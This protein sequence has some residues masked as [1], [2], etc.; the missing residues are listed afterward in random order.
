MMT[1]RVGQNNESGSKTIRE[2]N[3]HVDIAFHIKKTKPKVE[4]SGMIKVKMVM[5]T[6]Y[7][8]SKITLKSVHIFHCV[9]SAKDLP[10]VSISD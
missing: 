4:K 2:I 9:F 7:D 1:V 5:I 3:L 10:I 6:L 8:I